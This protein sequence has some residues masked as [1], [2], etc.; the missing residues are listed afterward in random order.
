MASMAEHYSVNRL[1]L[2]GLMETGPESK[3]PDNPRKQLFDAFIEHFYSVNSHEGVFPKKC[4]TCGKEYESLHHYICDTEA[5]AQTME[6]VGEIMGKSFTMV[7]RN[8]SCGNTLVVTI[9]EE[10]MPQITEFWDSLKLEAEI[11]GHSLKHI[12]TSFVEEWEN[13]IHSQFSCIKK[14]RR[15]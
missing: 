13:D 3:E 6:D 2:G 11:S 8:C 1:L 9:T 14:N 10:I 12:V 7:Y 5:K 4:R 15:F